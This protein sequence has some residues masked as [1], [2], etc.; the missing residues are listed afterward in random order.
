MA[1]RTS[2]TSL[3]RRT[4]STHRRESKTGM[5][6]HLFSRSTT[7]TRSSSWTASEAWSKPTPRSIDPPAHVRPWWSHVRGRF[8]A[9]ARPRPHLN[10]VCT[11]IPFCCITTPGVS[12]TPCTFLLFFP[13]LLPPPTPIFPGRVVFRT[14]GFLLYIDCI[15][16]VMREVQSRCIHHYPAP[17]RRFPWTVQYALYVDDFLYS[18]YPLS[19][20]FTPP[21]RALLDTLE[22]PR[23][24]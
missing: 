10:N 9:I 15:F 5:L 18:P 19:Y 23:Y 4:S 2:R 14:L 24:V 22:R 1:S 20:P 12:H 3:A 7:R 21:S 11:D 16:F 6:T 8:H 17:P 13:F